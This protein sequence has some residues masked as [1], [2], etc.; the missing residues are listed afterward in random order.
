MWTRI[1]LVVS[2]FALSACAPVQPVAQPAAA[3]T[4]PAEAGVAAS[5]SAQ[6]TSPPAGD[7]QPRL[8]LRVEL[9]EGDAIQVIDLGSEQVMADFPLG[10]ATGDSDLFA[11]SPDGQ[12]LF[13][14][15]QSEPST[16]YD[17]SSGDKREIDLWAH[18]HPD[19]R[20]NGLAWS[21]SQSWVSVATYRNQGGNSLWL[22]NQASDELIYV[23]EITGLPR[24]A[25]EADHLWFE[26]QAGSA[27]I[28]D[29]ATGEETAWPALSD[30]QITGL[31]TQDGQAPDGFTCAICNYPE[32]GRVSAYTSY[33]NGADRLY[34][35]LIDN[36]ARSATPLAVFHTQ[37]DVPLDYNLDVQGLLL[38]PT[39]G[40]YLLFVHERF[41]GL[42]D[43][44]QEHF[45]AA[46]SADGQPPFALVEGEAT[47]KLSNIMPAALSP[48]GTR[49]VGYRI[50]EQD[51]IPWFVSVVVVDIASR[52]VLYE[53]S[54]P[55]QTAGFFP[56]LTVYGADLV[57]PAP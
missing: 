19:E 46:W 33:A 37:R 45:F 34:Y 38:L 1:W 28:Y 50:A 42:S 36:Q 23:A 54:L 57:W 21:P 11:L 12:L 24:W 4:Q 15:A 52:E 16:L 8:A 44:P 55:A 3:A 40:D 47:N 29:P 5:P 2:A 35:Q 20:L 7:G 48:D 39:R 41:D 9:A 26:R 14:A 25:G 17:L 10:G 18:L 30:A 31:L 49:F 32:L 51:F 6:L 13:Y 53:Y 43:N 22:Y 56:P 27:L